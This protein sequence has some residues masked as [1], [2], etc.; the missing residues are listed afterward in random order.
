MT[1]NNKNIA[2]LQNEDPLN[3]LIQEIRLRK[4]SRQTEKTYTS[5]VRRYL[6]SGLTPRDFLLSKTHLSKS[7][8]RTTYFAL[9]FFHETVLH[10]PFDEDLPLVKKKAKLPVVLNKSEIEA[11]ILKTH[12]LKHRLAC[13]L[14]YYA[15]LRLDEA[16]NLRWEDIDLERAVIHVKIAKRDKE[17]VVFLHDKLKQALASYGIEKEGPV[18]RSR[19][20]NKRYH[21]RTIQKIVTTAAN[22]AKIAKNVTPHTL[23]HSFATHLLEAGAD[24]RYIQRLLGH[25]HLK[26]TS[27]YTHVANRDLD[28]LAG[29]L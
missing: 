14:L 15:G 9:Q 1:T 28:R 29:M 17:R 3:A 19:R 5:I 22:R 8:M 26:T 21:K 7:T 25:K 24:I 4:Y 18:L 12:N 2:P 20:T 10:Q 6:G 11:M 13:M 27:I 23:R 16:R